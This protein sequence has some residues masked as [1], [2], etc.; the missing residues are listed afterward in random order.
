VCAPLALSKELADDLARRGNH[1]DGQIERGQLETQSLKINGAEM[2]VAGQQ[3]KA[4]ERGGFG[5]DMR[6]IDLRGR[7]QSRLEQAIGNL[8]NIGIAQREGADQFKSPSPM[9]AE[10]FAGGVAFFSS[11]GVIRK[12]CQFL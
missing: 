10:K 3:N 11:F 6:I 4:A 12:P 7:Q 2:F 5:K 8:C 1:R 9:M